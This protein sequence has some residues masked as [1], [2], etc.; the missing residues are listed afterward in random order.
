MYTQHIY[1]FMLL[2]N[3]FYIYIAVKAQM[4]L[5]VRKYSRGRRSMVCFGDSF[6]H[7]FYQYFIR[8]A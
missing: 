6:S 3:T 2:L 5:R 1:L 8:L 7:L 4:K